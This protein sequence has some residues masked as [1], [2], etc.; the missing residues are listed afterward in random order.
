MDLIYFI[1]VLLKRKYLL[2]GIPILTGIITFLLVRN[3]PNVYKA[4][5]ELSTGLTEGSRI[6][7]G[8]QGYTGANEIQQQFSNIIELMRSK[9]L[10]DKLSYQLMLH[11]VESDVPFRNYTVEMQSL[12]GE[13]K[14]RLITFLN[15]KSDSLL[16]L[17]LGNPYH[18]KVF[19]AME[20]MKYDEKNISK[21][22]LVFR[23]QE[24]DFIRAEYE[25]ENPYLSAFVVNNLCKN[26]IEYYKDLTQTRTGETE[27]FFARLANEKKRE[28]D[29]KVDLLKQYKINNKVINLGQQT[30]NLEILTRDV[31]MM[32]ATISKLIPSLAGAIREIDS[33]LSPSERQY[34]EAGM[35][36][37]NVR[38]A[39]LKERLKDYTDLLIQSGNQNEALKDSIRN[40]KVV[41]DREIE[42]SSDEFIANPN[43]SKQELVMKKINYEL[44]L[45]IAEQ[46]VRSIDQELA[47][48]NSK[49]E[50]FTPLE[51][52]IQAYERDIQVAADAYLVILSKLNEASFFSSLGVNIEQI[53]FGQPGLPEASKKIVYLLLAVMISFVLT[54]VVIFVIEYLDQTIKTPTKF[55]KLTGL[56]LTGCLN[57][58]EVKSLD[59]RKLFSGTLPGLEAD[60]FRELLRSIRYEIETKNKDRKKILITSTDSGTG[61]TIFLISLAYSLGLSAKRVLLIDGNFQD[62]ALTRSF[63]ASTTLEEYIRGDL[64]LEDTITRTSLERVDVIGC[65]GGNNTPDEIAGSEVLIAKIDEASSEYDVVLIE[66]PALNKYSGSKEFINTIESVVCVFDAR[67]VIDSPDKNSIDFLNE[68]GEKFTGSILNKVELDNLEEIYGEVVKNRTKVRKYSKKILKGNFAS[69]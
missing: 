29:E 66:G 16:F 47:R 63:N 6:T 14:E 62:N 56:S 15:N 17:D 19:D 53:Q 21:V 35:E 20:S 11:D 37:L 67:K 48:L 43:V 58:L 46:S 65:M 41:L 51:A 69:S 54:I 60:V 24:S 45:E 23:I 5:A 9:R 61:K 31:Q 3:L 68:Q 18:K 28:L 38:I 64:M 55:V 25:S 30:E 1:R 32:R 27:E 44:E 36:P 4:E 49:F 10:L 8:D 12:V 52:T 26:F 34:F 22:L 42:K 59:L 39:S 57:L 50:S 33:K 40:I 13:S 2:I 7:I